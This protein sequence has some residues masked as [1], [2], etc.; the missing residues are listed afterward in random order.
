VGRLRGVGITN[1]R[2]TTI[3][4]DKTTGRPLSNA[5]VWCDGRTAGIAA[6]LVGKTS[7]KSKDQ[8]RPRCGLPIN[9]YFSA[10]KLCWL[11]KHSQ[12]VMAA[13]AEG[14]CLFGTVDTWIIWNL[15]GGVDGGVH[16][17]DVTNASRT[18]LMNIHTLQWDPDLCQFFG[19]PMDILPAIKSSSETYGLIAEGSLKGVPICGCLGDQQAALVGQQC[20]SPGDAKNTYGTGCFLLKNTGEQPVMSNNGLLTTVAYQL[21]PGKPVSYGLEG[22]VS[23]AGQSVRWLKD[24]IHLLTSASQIE[25]YAKE[26][27]DTGNVYFVPAFSG[28]WAPHWQPNARG[29]INGLTYSTTTAHLCRAALEAVCFQSRE[30]LDAM[31]LDSVLPLT[32]LRV[33]GGMTVNETLLRLQADLLGIP[34]VRPE[35]KE[36]SVLGAA[37]AAGLDQGV[38]PDCS[39]LPTPHSS[40]F[41]PSISSDESDRRFKR[42]KEAVTRCMDWHGNSQHSPDHRQRRKSSVIFLLGCVTGAVVGGALVL[43]LCRR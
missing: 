6:S 16:V 42:W 38:W 35:V 40:P 5:I 19:I 25:E 34:V 18:M 1:Q 13:I 3:V 32:R 41:T 11:M 7:S 9:P 8:L 33:D 12:P 21:G 17:T 22:A 31:N 14:N 20:F 28:L 36:M 24:N 39:H 10:L 15:T 29:L 2:E 27:D 23:S 30:V 4:W 43:A 26:V 37:I